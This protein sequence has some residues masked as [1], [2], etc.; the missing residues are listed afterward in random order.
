ML[1]LAFKYSVLVFLAVCA[2]LQL[3]AIRNHLRGLQFI[4]NRGLEISISIIIL[5]A[6]AGLFFFWNYFNAVG[7]IEGSQQAEFFAISGTLAL[8]FTLLV[9]SLI[10]R[11]MQKHE[12]SSKHGLQALENATFLQLLVNFWVK[13]SK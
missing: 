7:V 8:I 2:L 9:S 13:Q 1:I 10:N 12:T 6:V 11:S 4:K 3:A 5:V